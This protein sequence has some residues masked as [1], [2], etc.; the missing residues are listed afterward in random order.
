M[1]SKFKVNDKNEV[2]DFDLDYGDIISLTTRQQI[3]SYVYNY[4][5][6]IIHEQF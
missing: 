1:E 2:V 6:Q 4:N 5:K 3:A